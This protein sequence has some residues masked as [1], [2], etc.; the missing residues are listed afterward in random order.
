MYYE[1]VYMLVERENKVSFTIH[2]AVSRI[3][4]NLYVYIKK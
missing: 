1:L 4:K 2:G 3:K